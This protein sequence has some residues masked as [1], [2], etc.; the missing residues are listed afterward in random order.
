MACSV[1]RRCEEAFEAED[2]VQ[3]APLC[4]KAHAKNKKTRHLALAAESHF[5]LSNLDEVERLCTLLLETPRKPQALY[6]L[7][8]AALERGQRDQAKSLLEEAYAEALQQHGTHAPK[9][10]R[11]AG[12]AAYLLA[13]MSL[14]DNKLEDSAAWVQRGLHELKEQADLKT[15]VALLTVLHIIEMWRGNELAAETALSLTETLHRQKSKSHQEHRSLLLL[16]AFQSLRQERWALAEQQFL[17]LLSFSANKHCD[18]ACQPA[19]YGLARAHMH[20]G[21]LDK[22]EA[23]LNE[24]LRLLT[25]PVSADVL[26]FHA[27]LATEQKNYSKVLEILPETQDKSLTETNRQWMAILRGNA[28]AKLG[29]KFEAEVVLN[30]VVRQ[31]EGMH[32]SLTAPGHR[33]SFLHARSWA[34]EWLFEEYIQE[35]KVFEALEVAERLMAPTFM[36]L[37]SSKLKPHLSSAEE[38]HALLARTEKDPL[39]S[40]STASKLSFEKALELLS[41]DELLLFFSSEQW[42]FRLWFHEGKLKEVQKLSLKELKPRLEAFALSPSSPEEAEALGVLLW[43]QGLSKGARVQI[44]GQDMLRKLPWAALRV[45]GQWLAARHAMAWAPSLKVAALLRARARHAGEV[46]V[47]GNPTGDLPHAQAEALQVAQRLKAAPFLGVRARRSVFE[48]LSGAQF[49]HL[50]AHTHI[51]TEGA[52][53]GLADG[54]LYAHELLERGLAPQTVVL[55]SCASAKSWDGEGL[56][57]LSGSFLAAGSRQVVASLRSMEDAVSAEFMQHFYA[58]GGLE[59]PAWA[60]S[61]AQ[62]K[63]A[64]HARV[65]QWSAFVLWGTVR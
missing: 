10:Q 52:N 23:A 47:V 57:S 38:V 31:Y 48:R 40:D 24:H 14:Y 56:M 64:G 34:F 35:G 26:S 1:E 61:K 39:E 63:M 2:F 9:D 46:L 13:W 54:K 4:E 50:A 44:V 58:E 15:E 21:Q 22:A 59:E 19:W 33:S 16:R 53:I 62:T 17:R 7:G 45:Q 28:L 5:Q 51:E 30:K 55:S 41:P 25:T 6:L 49:L 8:A 32:R 42:F 29:R 11:A 37:L 18:D 3:A 43:P 27:E 36:E 20:Q 12:R 65:E 60:L